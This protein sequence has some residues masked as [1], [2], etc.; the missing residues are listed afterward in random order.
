MK[1]KVPV[2][3][4]WR[5]P[6]WTAQEFTQSVEPHR[7]KAQDKNPHRVWNPP[8]K[9]NKQ[10]TRNHRTTAWI[11]LCLTCRKSWRESLT[12]PNSDTPSHKY[13]WKF[14]ENLLEAIAENV[15]Q[16]QW[17]RICHCM[18]TPVCL[19]LTFKARRCVFSVSFRFL[20]SAQQIRD[21]ASWS[22]TDA[23]GT[24]LRGVCSALFIRPKF[25]NVFR[26]P[27]GSTK[28]PNICSPMAWKVTSN[29][30]RHVFRCAPV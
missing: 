6:E 20:L 14:G 10:D 17:W 7:S 12:M 16:L 13:V 5:S 29:K 15:K 18:L 11:H 23:E 19:G 21:I 22:A 8:W 27:V 4:P 9:G 24:K 3:F 28:L 26:C 2:S 1:C 30:I 25:R